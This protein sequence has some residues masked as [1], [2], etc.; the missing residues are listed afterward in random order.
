MIFCLFGIH[1]F[2]HY[3]GKP[4]FQTFLSGDIKRVPKEF[5]FCSS[6]GKYFKYEYDSIGGRWTAL[7][8]KETAILEVEISHEKIQISDE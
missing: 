5:A 7:D 4:F 1:S 3:Y 8:E 2:S 6:C